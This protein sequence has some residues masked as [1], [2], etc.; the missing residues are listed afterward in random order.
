M[1]NRYIAFI[2]LLLFAALSAATAQATTI[3]YPTGIFPTDVQNVQAAVDQGGTV[4]LKATDNVG[5]PLAFNF[6]PSTVGPGREVSIETSVSLLGEQ[7]A[8]NRTTINGGVNPIRIFGGTDSI[9]GIKFNGPLDS[10]IQIHATTGLRIVGNEI[11]NVVP[12][13]LVFP[14]FSFTITE[15]I[16]AA[17]DNGRPADISGNLIISG[18]SIGDLTGNFAIGVQVDSV[19]ANVTISNNSFQLGQLASDPGFVNSAAIACVRCHSAVTISGNIITIGPG[20]VAS[21]IT[22]FGGPDAR[23]RVFSNTINSAGPV[24]D[25]IDLIGLTGDPGVTVSAIVENNTIN[26]LNTDLEFGSG[27][28]LLGTVTNSTVQGNIVTG[29]GPAALY[30]LG[31]IAPGELVSSDRFLFNDI[32]QLTPSVASIAFLEQT[33]NNV[34]RG[35]CVSVLD[36]GLNNNISCP[37]PASHTASFPTA[38]RQ[39]LIQRALEAQSQVRA[40]ITE[41]FG[42]F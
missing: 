14:G 36:L 10:A 39:Q 11:D 31:A 3:V 21:G 22:V 42:T 30:A 1:N 23:Y 32:A 35:Q 6:G 12:F 27:I 38:T 40:L 5:H 9:E 33:A 8:G 19:A 18:N 34:V 24:A 17:V 15:G 7:T 26:L 25:G 13:L 16:V 28:G 41:R 20:F 37:N 29:N 4:L 2:H